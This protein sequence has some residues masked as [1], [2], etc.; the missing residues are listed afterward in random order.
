[1]TQLY[2]PIDANEEDALDWYQKWRE[3][4]YEWVAERS[5]DKIADVVIVVPDF[6]MLLVDLA[7]DSRV[8]VKVKAQ[9]GLAIAYVLAPVDLMP[10]AV[11][12]VAGLADDAT[13]MAVLLY[14]LKSVN[15]LNPAIIREH[16]RGA[17]DAI[18]VIDDVYERI[19]TNVEKIIN[20]RVWQRIQKTF[21]SNAEKSQESERGRRF[22]KRLTFRRASEGE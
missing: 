11:L 2:Q 1:M 6:F 4:I 15:E 17:G 19:S 3:R 7:R 8:P 9:I 22:L 21:G 13:V 16:W 18:E 5:D 12:G 14:S 10:E 20:S